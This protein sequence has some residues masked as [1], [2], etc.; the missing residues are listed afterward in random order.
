MEGVTAAGVVLAGGRSSR[1]GRDKASMPWGRSSLLGQVVDVLVAA[2]DGPVVVVRGP[3]Q[4]LPALP[5][6]V[7]LVDDPVPDLGPVQ[8]I[9][10]GLRAVAGVATVAYVASTDLPLLDGAVVRRTVAL[11]DGTS[12]AD[13]AVPLVDG[14]PQLLAA[15]YRVPVADRLEAALAAG[16]RRLRTVVAGW[17]VRYLRPEDLLS[18]PAVAA[19]DP[20]LASFT[21]V[22]DPQEYARALAA[23]RG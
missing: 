13:A 16:E 5:A 6:G 19:A 8:G 9:A 3:G 18:D 10:A 21:N 12:G 11:L 2:L 4:P 14:R 17:E 22:N 1:M 20:G 7:R 23:R 15:T